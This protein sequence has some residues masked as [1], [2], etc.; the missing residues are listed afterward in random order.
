MNNNYAILEKA[1]AFQIVTD[2]QTARQ[3]I[4]GRSVRSI[5]HESQQPL[6]ETWLREDSGAPILAFGRI[7]RREPNGE[8]I[9]T[10][11]PMAFVPD[12]RTFG[13]YLRTYHDTA[14][15][16]TLKRIAVT[17]FLILIAEKSKARAMRA[18]ISKLQAGGEHAAS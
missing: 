15:R 4:L 13:E 5:L 18:F 14:C 6:F 8:R 7:F 17:A 1:D 3:P 10:A 12:L 11:L 9:L 2:R 16:D